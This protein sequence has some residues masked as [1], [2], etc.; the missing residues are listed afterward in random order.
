MYMFPYKFVIMIALGHLYPL[1]NV[2]SDASVWPTWLGEMVM[3]PSRESVDTIHCLSAHC[4]RVKWE[5]EVYIAR[6]SLIAFFIVYIFLYFSTFQLL[7][8][9]ITRGN[10]WRYPFDKFQAVKLFFRAFLSFL[11]LR[12][13]TTNSLRLLFASFSPPGS[14]THRG[15]AVPAEPKGA[16]GDFLFALSHKLVPSVL[17]AMLITV[18]FVG[19]RIRILC[20]EPATRCETLI[21]HFSRRLRL[22]FSRNS[23]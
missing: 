8:M 3:S 7:R 15:I 16:M 10:C 11:I 18:S 12:P 19:Y 6:K 23:P 14:R 21:F 20:L 22:P 5:D 1:Q 9:S 4:A 17:W 13:R 2:L